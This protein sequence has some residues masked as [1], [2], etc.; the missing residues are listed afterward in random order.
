MKGGEK[1]VVICAWCS[2]DIGQDGKKPVNTVT[3]GICRECYILQ[4][5]DL[6]KTTVENVTDKITH[7]INN[8]YGR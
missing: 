8:I 7:F 6:Q 1:M 2:K 4:L 3:H 5:N